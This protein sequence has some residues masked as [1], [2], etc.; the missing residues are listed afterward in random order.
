[1][2]LTL[3]RDDRIRGKLPE[4]RVGSWLRLVSNGQG[5]RAGAGFPGFGVLIRQL[6]WPSGCERVPW[7]GSLTAGCP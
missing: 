7:G 5:G 1:M 6:I 4:L 3:I 2:V